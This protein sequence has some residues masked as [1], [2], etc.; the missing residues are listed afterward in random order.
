MARS[1][2]KTDYSWQGNAATLALTSG[3][4]GIVTIN[5]PNIASTLTRSRGAVVGSIDGATDNDKTH[6]TCGLIVGTPE[7]VAVGVTAFPDP[8]TD[9]DA[10]WVWH[11]FL[12]LMA[13]GTSTDQPGLTDRLVIDSK[14]MRRMKQLQSV[15]FIARAT[16]LAGTPVTDVMVGVRQLFGE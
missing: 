5:T 3:N 13:Q 7:Q 15:V 11:G 6:I 4:V 2:R 16:A 1:G 10:E 8:F 12:L 9:M 14:A